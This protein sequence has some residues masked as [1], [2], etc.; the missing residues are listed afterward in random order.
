MTMKDCSC[1]DPYAKT[2][3]V[4]ESDDITP[5]GID[6]PLVAKIPVVLSQT[7]IQID[8]EAEIEFDTPYYEIKRIKKDVYL[9]QC[10][11]IPGAGKF[12]KGVQVT[13]KVFLAG[14]V[15]KNIEYSTAPKCGCIKDTTVDIPFQCV[16][17]V[18]F[19]HAPQFN[20]RKPQTEIDLICDCCQ[21]NCDDYVIGKFPCEQN[22][23]DTI[24]FSEKPYCELVSAKIY[25]TDLHKDPVPMDC[26]CSEYT[27]YKTLVEKMVIYINLKLLQLQQVNIKDGSGCSCNRDC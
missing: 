11:L 4:C 2:L 21:C 7:N 17:E 19:D 15:R 20:I 13:G 5:K 1:Y 12:K 23:Q 16:A 24:Y 9:T 25:E 26:S 8:V 10:K 14:Y 3:P 6:G 27:V 18:E 22:F